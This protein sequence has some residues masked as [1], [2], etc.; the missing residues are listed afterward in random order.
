MVIQ[1]VC[2]V[3]QQYGVPFAQKI[4]QLQQYYQNCVKANNLFQEELDKTI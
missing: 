1:G 2:E 3:F 4:Y